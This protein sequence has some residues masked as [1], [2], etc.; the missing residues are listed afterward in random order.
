MSQPAPEATSLR[1]AAENEVGPTHEGDLA[2]EWRG[3]MPVP[4][5]KRYGG[6]FSMATLW[7]TSQLSP[8]PLYIGVIGAAS[9]I[10]LGIVPNVLAIVLG[11]ILGAA[12]IGAISLMGPPSGAAQ[13]VLARLPF[14]KSITLV[15]LVA[16]VESLIFVALGAIFGA[17]A[18]QVIVNMPFA[19]ALILVFGLEAVISVT[20][21]E[22][23]HR[24]EKWMA[25]AVGIGF[26]IL[27]VV[28]VSKAGSIHINQTMHGADAV[29][30]FILMTA[31]AFGFAFGWAINA[32]DYCRYLP[33][34]TSPRALFGWVFAG[35]FVGCVWLEVLGLAAASILPNLAPMNSIYQLLGGGFLGVVVLLTIYFGVVA[36]LCI[37]DYSA[38][39][40]VLA[41]GIRVPR[42]VMTAISACLC[43]GLTYWLATGNLAA[44][45]ENAVLLSTYWVGP[46]VGIIAVDWWR[47]D[48]HSVAGVLNY[49]QL[50]SGLNAL[51]AVVVAFVVSLPFSNTTVGYDLAQHG[52]FL[53]VLFGGASTNWL[54]GGDLAYP[55]GLVVGA[56]LY[57]LLE[58]VTGH[59]L[60]RAKGMHRSV[61]EHATVA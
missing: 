29:G 28:V 47:R 52:G 12:A 51:V 48:S 1:Q 26:L 58:R 18:L 38:G 17:Q 27:T 25:V 23:L 10:G 33:A 35:L 41:A 14:G 53:A 30:S 2:I 22:L 42:P 49:R 56:A 24:F 39:L 20:G 44:N 19:V 36:Q 9:F 61:E 6:P 60:G 45:A 11:N 15:G 55:V 8:I 54:H 46:F 50:P 43:F 31:I 34:T 5:D 4:P 40:Q 21:Y 37:E 13:M 32:T 57:A 7:F 3:L 16:Y 59:N